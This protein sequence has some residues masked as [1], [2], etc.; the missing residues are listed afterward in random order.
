LL[1]GL[2]SKFDSYLILNLQF[3]CINAYFIWFVYFEKPCA[4]AEG[5]IDD[6]MIDDVL[7]SCLGENRAYATGATSVRC[8]KRVRQICRRFIAFCVLV[9]FVIVFRF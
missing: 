6:L 9:G 3:S 7:A 8:V 1:A 2:I 5:C 4:A